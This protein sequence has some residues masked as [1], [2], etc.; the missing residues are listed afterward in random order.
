[1]MV[2]LM[3]IIIPNLAE[4]AVLKVFMYIFYFLYLYYDTAQ[5]DCKGTVLLP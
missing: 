5:T 4:N 3:Q 1:M 2:L